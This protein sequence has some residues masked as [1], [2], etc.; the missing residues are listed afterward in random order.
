MW[1]SISLLW[2]WYKNRFYLLAGDIICGSTN[3]LNTVCYGYSGCYWKISQV[4]RLF[5]DSSVYFLLSALSIYNIANT[6]TFSFHICFT[7]IRYYLY[8]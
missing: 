8:F 5:F 6:K 4:T 7:Q 1:Q 3:Y 2:H